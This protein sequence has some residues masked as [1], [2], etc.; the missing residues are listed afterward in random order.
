[1]GSIENHLEDMGNEPEYLRRRV[2]IL[3]TLKANIDSAAPDVFT[4][5]EVNQ[6]KKKLDEVNHERTRKT[7][8]FR[9]KL[10]IYENRVQKIGTT[11]EKRS[12]VIDTVCEATFMAQEEDIMDIFHT[13]HCSLT[14]E[15]EKSMEMLNTS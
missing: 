15:M 4:R 1:M 2:V 9:E 5:H 14:S 13:E 12:M 8:L 10:D 3:T 11:L 6:V 7:K